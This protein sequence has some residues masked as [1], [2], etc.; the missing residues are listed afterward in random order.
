MFR[1][2]KLK[3]ESDNKK[4]CFRNA[5]LKVDCIWWNNEDEVAEKLTT[6]A[7]THNRAGKEIKLGTLDYADAMD[8][9]EEMYCDE[10]ATMLTYGLEALAKEYGYTEDM[11]VVNVGIE[12]KYSTSKSIEGLLLDI[13]NTYDGISDPA[14]KKEFINKVD[15]GLTTYLLEKNDRPEVH[16]GEV[17]KIKIPA[18]VGSEF[19]GDRW[20]IVISNERHAEHSWVINVVYLDGH[21]V[22]NYMSQM[23]IKNS[24]FKEGRLE[25][26]P[27]R[28]NIT[29]I[30]S[31]DKKKLLE[32]KGVVSDE[33]MNR[34]MKRI[35]KQLEI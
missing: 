21:P 16:R 30:C 26:I 13:K 18:T 15:G 14:E 9:L 35:A 27:S 34:L 11:D 2:S 3:K 12:A 28:V 29:D 25:K 19:S 33:F 20:V 1:K 6:L 8:L 24:D 5:Q 22:K 32:K 17:W 4:E 23:I 31:I 7:M 10:N